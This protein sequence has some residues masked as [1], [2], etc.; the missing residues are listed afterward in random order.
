LIGCSVVPTNLSQQLYVSPAFTLAAVKQERV[1]LL[2][3]T[4]GVSYEGVRRNAATHLSQALAQKY[5]QQVVKN[6]QESMECIQNHN[7]IDAYARLINNYQDTAILEKKTLREVGKAIGVRYLLYSQLQRHHK[8][9]GYVLPDNPLSY[10]VVKDVRVYTQVW[11]VQSGEVVWEGE[12]IATHTEDLFT[13]PVLFDEVVKAACYGVINAMLYTP[14]PQVPVAKEDDKGHPI[15]EGSIKKVLESF[16]KAYSKEQLDVALNCFL[17]A[18][19][20]RKVKFEKKFKDRSN[21]SLKFTNLSIKGESASHATVT[22]DALLSYRLLQTISKEKRSRKLKYVIAVTKLAS[23]NEW[24]IVD[25]KVK[26]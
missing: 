11:D 7:L 2:P 20:D 14:P 6:S 16:A 12:G 19:W 10:K 17:E 18:T 25:M 22:T 13:Q 15:D 8:K 5:G 21:I 24:K 3:V 26:E 1:A 23:T 9:S 4:A